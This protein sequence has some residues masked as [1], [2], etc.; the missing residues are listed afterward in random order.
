MTGSDRVWLWS[1]SRGVLEFAWGSTLYLS[2]TL[3]FFVWKNQCFPASAS[4]WISRNSRP[5]L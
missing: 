4:G 3:P 5:D 2:V 1:V